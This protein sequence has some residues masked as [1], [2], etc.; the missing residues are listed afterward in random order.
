MSMGN[1]LLKA[2]KDIGVYLMVTVGVYLAGFVTYIVIGFLQEK[3]LT[4]MGLNST[5]SAYTGIT[6]MFTAAYTAI[7][8]IVAIVT[9][10]TGL[11]TLQVV[12]TTFGFKLNFS[13][14]SRV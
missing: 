11:L 10:I 9:I 8:A 13:G 3:V 7:A 6:T 1:N 5:G 2:A 12:L 4:S 14:G